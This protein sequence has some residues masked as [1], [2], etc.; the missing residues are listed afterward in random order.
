VSE[1]VPTVV[2]VWPVEGPCEP[3]GWFV[4][5]SFDEPVANVSADDLVL[6]AGS[7]LSVSGDQEGPYY[8]KLTGVPVLTTINATLGGDIADMDGSEIAPYQWTWSMCD[9]V[10]GD[11][12]GVC[13]NVDNCPL[14]ANPD[15]RD[16]DGDGVGDACDACP[17]LRPHA[18]VEGGC[19]PIVRV[20][21]DGDGDVD[22]EDF[23]H[24]QA[25]LSGPGLLQ[26]DPD[27]QN[28]KLDEDADVDDADVDIFLRCVAGPG[29]GADPVCAN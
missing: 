4:V 20:D 10:D 5:V 28:A 3:A 6:S 14:L 19:S 23:G 24:M 11:G 1:Q 7:V 12:D 2:G 8:F 18:S 27:C 21:M 17:N 25:C 13:E 29:V 15:Q 26:E 9:C 16:S 22:M